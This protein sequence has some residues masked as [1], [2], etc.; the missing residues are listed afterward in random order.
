MK[1]QPMP[2]IAREPSG[3]R[4]LVLCGQPGQ[5]QG[6][7]SVPRWHP[8]RRARFPGRDDRQARVHSRDVCRQD[9]SRLLQA[10]RDG[11]GDERGGQVGVGPQQP[12]VAG[13]RRP[14]R[15]PL[16]VGCFDLPRRGPHVG[17]SV[18]QLLLQ[19]VLDERALLFDDE[20]L[21][22]ARAR[23]RGSMVGSS[24]QTTPTLC[25]LI[26]RR[27]HTSASRPRSSS[28]WRVSLKAL[29]PAMMPNR[30]CGPS[31]TL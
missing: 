2:A 4:V 6:W 27:R 14:I 25:S 19:L 16:A 29:P 1:W 28:A 11:L 24:G 8:R 12:L 23:S 3:T 10:A 7:R 31:I 18:V 20:N 30:S 21:P 26:P 22:Q 9:T 13:S 5:N 15:R 17:A